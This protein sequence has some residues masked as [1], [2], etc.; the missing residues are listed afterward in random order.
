VLFTH[1][2]VQH[3]L[4]TLQDAPMIAQLEVAVSQRAGFPAQSPVQQS[5]FV[6]HDAPAL[7]HA[8][9]QTE[10]PASVGVHEPLQQVSPAP[11]GALRGR[12]GPVPKAHRPLAL[13]HPPQQ[14]SKG[15]PVQVS[16][17]ARHGDA[18]MLH[19]WNGVAHSPE[20]QSP[21]TEQEPPASAQIAPPQIPPLHASEQQSDASVHAAPSIRQ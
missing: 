9:V 15:V 5:S 13:S 7:A 11:Q 17:A 19:T 21:S 1:D 20:Q 12:Q 16:P 3:S 14:G 6:L 8:D 2:P 18:P 4:S 10:T